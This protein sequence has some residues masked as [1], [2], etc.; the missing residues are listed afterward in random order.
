[1]THPGRFI[2]TEIV[3]SWAEHQRQ[4]MRVTNDDRV[5]EER[6]RAFHIAQE[7]PLISE[8]IYMRHCE[9]HQEFASSAVRTASSS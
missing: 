7:P 1:M 8:M 5:I 2:E 3:E 9:G 4:F 6:V